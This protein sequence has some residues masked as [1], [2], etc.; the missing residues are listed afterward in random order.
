MAATAVPAA[1]FAQ[2][3]QTAASVE[4][5]GEKI[6]ISDFYVSELANDWDYRGKPI[7]QS[8]YVYTYGVYDENG[9]L[10]VGD[11]LTEGKDFTVSYANNNGI[12]TATVTIKGIGKYTGTKVVTFEIKPNAPETTK[13]TVKNGKVTISWS[14]VEGATK[15]NVYYS[16][17]NGAIKKLVSTKKTKFSI[18]KFDTERNSYEFY[19]TTVQKVD[20]KNYESVYSNTESRT[21]LIKHTG[22]TD[23]DSISVTAKVYEDKAKITIK[24]FDFAK[25]MKKASA[26][27]PVRV[28]F[29]MRDL[30][31]QWFNEASVYV[32]MDKNSIKN[33]YYSYYS[34][35]LSVVPC[36]FSWNKSKNTL[37]VTVKCTEN[38]EGEL[39]PNISAIKDCNGLYVS[40]YKT[41]KCKM[42]NN[43]V[44]HVDEA[45]FDVTTDTSDYYTWAT[46]DMK[47]KVK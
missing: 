41:S 13:A 6:D 44:T 7:E 33:C 37:T 47:L 3:M 10:Q 34:D 32:D 23:F 46:A 29:G 30:N 9:G 21:T 17:N 11:E 27:D 28:E 1:A 12:G 42:V 4:V 24:G 16:E 40:A 2:D 19:V 18:K 14:K 45:F 39:T 8:V 43:Y 15:Y 38:E 5:P 22:K 36:K 25:Y 35:D 26:K 20:G 31:A